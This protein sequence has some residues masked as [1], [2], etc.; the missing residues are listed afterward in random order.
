MPT[1]CALHV[2]SSVRLTRATVTFATCASTDSITTASGSITVLGSKTTH[3]ST[4]TYAS[5]PF[6]WLQWSSWLVQVSTIINLLIF[7]SDID[8][9]FTTATLTSAK[10]TSLVP[11]IVQDN[12]SNAQITYDLTL[13]VTL[14]L[15]LLFLPFLVVLV[16]VQTQNFMLNQTT[17]SRFSKHRRGAVNEAQLAAL[18]GSD[19]SFD[20]DYSA[21]NSTKTP[22]SMRSREGS[23]NE[24]SAG[25]PVID[26]GRFLC[27]S[28]SSKKPNKVFKR[29][30]KDPN[31]SVNQTMSPPTEYQTL[32]D[33]AKP[34]GTGLSIVEKYQRRQMFFYAVPEEV[35][36][37][38]LFGPYYS[39]EHLRE[40]YQN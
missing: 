37:P 21:V 27:G 35:A 3:T 31:S 17:N 38:G 7:H 36:Q 1:C 10:E 9:E 15:A 13:I 5:R 25:S 28:G 2:R 22:N 19:S 23:V 30:I 6:T 16:V 12:I 24:H 26:C 20:D 8:L 40:A 11:I 29:V 32:R 34:S 33:N 18:T 14:V 4:S 39:D